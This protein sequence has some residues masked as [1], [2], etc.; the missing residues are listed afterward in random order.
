MCVCVCMCAPI[1]QINTTKKKERERNLIIS[2]TKKRNREWEN[3]YHKEMNKNNKSETEKKK[4]SNNKLINNNDNNI[5]QNRKWQNQ[6]KFES[7]SGSWISKWNER[8]I[9]MWM[10][11]IYFFLLHCSAFHQE[12]KNCWFHRVSLSTFLS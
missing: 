8:M 4:I 1:G 7:W 2:E 9:Q 3:K 6:I 5:E 12:Q 10:C 11:A